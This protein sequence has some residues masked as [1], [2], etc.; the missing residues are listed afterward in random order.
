MLGI[1]VGTAI[2]AA[3]F[4]LALL[5]LGSS[6]GVGLFIIGLSVSLAMIAVAGFGGAEDPFAVGI[7]AAIAAMI[8]GGVIF[9]VFLFTGSGTVTLLLPAAMLGVGGTVAHP[10]D[11]DPQR[12][13]MRLIIS[14]VA[15]VAVVAG[16]LVT[17]N[18][19]ALLAP[20]LPLPAIAVADWL[21]DRSKT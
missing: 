2:A 4:W 5:L 11:G 10:G 18:V 1:V 12:V 21:T 6:V 7:K 15:A 9:A 8:A 17:V 14:G 16:G 3:G 20:L 19:W 13:T